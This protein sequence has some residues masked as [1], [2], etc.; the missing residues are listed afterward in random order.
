MGKQA[1]MAIIRRGVLLLAI[2]ATCAAAWADDK[3]PGE[4]NRALFEQVKKM[5]SAEQQAWLAQ[6]ERRALLA[7]Q[8]TLPPDEAAKQQ[9]RIKKVLHQKVVTWQVLGQVL[10]ETEAREKSV[11][12]ARLP[13]LKEETVKADTKK[14]A[15][16]TGPV[17]HVVAKP[18]AV[19]TAGKLPPGSVTVD[20]EELEARIAG[21]NLAF[22]EF[23]TGLGEKDATWNAAKLEPL[24]ER[25][26]I[27]VLRH[28]D[29]GL[30]RNVVPKGERSGVTQ[31]ESTRS[32]ISEFSA[33]VVEARNRANDP[34]SF[35]DEAERQ[36]ELARLGA[37]S[38]GLAELGGK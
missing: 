17:T 27:L 36:A 16:K 3:K 9:A 28:S 13:E 8:L 32:A 30:H 26:K 6:L 15:A 21:C 7:A 22:R 14:P 2:L 20:M 29:L 38:R 33:R 37:I 24:F 10:A 25:L 34:K 4:P 11:E 35:A 12:V 31:L 1:N 18:Q 23:E 19:D 5:S